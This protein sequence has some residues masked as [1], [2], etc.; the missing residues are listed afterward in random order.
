MTENKIEIF[1]SQNGGIEFTG[2]LENQTVARIATVQ[3]EGK[4]QVKRDIE[5]FNLERKY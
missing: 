2:D 1:Q 5:Y 3:I 4:K